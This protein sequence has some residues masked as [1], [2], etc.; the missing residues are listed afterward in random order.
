MSETTTDIVIAGGGM[1]GSSLAVALA[2][3]GLDVT[4]VEAIPR[5]STEQ[6]S[7]DER[8]TALSRSTQRSFEAMGIWP[9]V[10]AAS[11]PISSIHVSD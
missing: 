5:G 4:V 8:S 10:V 6:P 9:D 1:V 11:T 2:P 3:L 7:F